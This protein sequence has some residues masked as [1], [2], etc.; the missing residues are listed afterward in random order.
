MNINVGQ[1]IIGCEYIS[2]I[3]AYENFEKNKKKRLKIIFSIFPYLDWRFAKMCTGL[4]KDTIIKYAS[5]NN[6]D[7]AEDTYNAYWFWNH[8]KT[9]GNLLL[10]DD[11]QIAKEMSVKKDFIET[12]ILSVCNIAKSISTEKEQDNL[13]NDYFKNLF[14]KY[15]SSSKHMRDIESIIKNIGKGKHNIENLSSCMLSKI[16]CEFDKIRESN[17]SSLE[18]EA[19]IF[20]KSHNIKYYPQ[21]KFD[22]CV[23]R[24]LL[25]FDF[26]FVIN[27]KINCLELDGR[28]HFEPVEYFGGNNTFE[29]QKLHDA[30]KDNYCNKNGINLFRIRYDEDI[31]FKLDNI[32]A[33][34]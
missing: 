27:E 14:L 26:A 33:D 4:S 6:I 32:I 23:D 15:K 13:T 5:E 30:I 20:F 29:K 16:C 25:P 11:Y 34:L 7:L 1:Y 19:N 10:H 31:T 24:K 3:R 9:I 18:R 28:Q 12:Y 8:Y 2:K 17:M 22:D 21:Y